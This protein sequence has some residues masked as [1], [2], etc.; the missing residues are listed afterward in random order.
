M[1]TDGARL[2][3]ETDECPVGFV[4]GMREFSPGIVFGRENRL[5]LVPVLVLP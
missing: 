5:L 1:E 4:L 3:L 2:R